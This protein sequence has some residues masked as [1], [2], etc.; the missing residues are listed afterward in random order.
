[1]EMSEV[2]SKPGFWVEDMKMRLFA[3]LHNFMEVN[4]LNKSE[5]AVKL[6]FTKSYITQVLNGNFNHSLN[7][8]AELA[9]AIG[10]VP[11]L[12]FESLADTLEY[13]K[14]GLLLSK[15]IDRNRIKLYDNI[16]NESLP[17]QENIAETKYI[18]VLKTEKQQSAIS[19]CREY[20]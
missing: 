16:L 11:R 19:F 14:M 10:M 9:L 18:I 7:K 12:E 8:L 5:L 4:N 3:E 17:I 6:G 1:M 20:L 15:S 13:E 2:I